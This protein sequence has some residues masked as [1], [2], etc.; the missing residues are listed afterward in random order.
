MKVVLSLA[1]TISLRSHIF[2]SE[3]TIYLAFTAAGI[4]PRLFLQFI[5]QWTSSFVNICLSAEDS[6]SRPLSLY[7]WMWVESIYWRPTYR[8]VGL[9]DASYLVVKRLGRCLLA[10]DCN[11]PNPEK[12]CHDLYDQQLQQS[13]N[14]AEDDDTG[15]GDVQYM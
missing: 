5:C 4:R 6:T 12:R 15:V 9:Y 8:S 14:H 3:I 13:E 7:C 1:L 10:L 2:A 11:S